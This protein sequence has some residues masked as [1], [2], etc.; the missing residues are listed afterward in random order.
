[1]VNRYG[2]SCVTVYF[3]KC[4][5]LSPAAPWPGHLLLTADGPI[6]HTKEGDIGRIKDYSHDVT[7]A[8]EGRR[9]EQSVCTVS[10]DDISAG[11]YG[12][13]REK[14]VVS[15]DADVGHG[16]RWCHWN[17]HEKMQK[18][19]THPDQRPWRSP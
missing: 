12:P 16:R 5:T 3:C 17:R 18:P 8:G 15:P 1:M 6:Q 4:L 10:C 11:R 14:T 9:C 19:L 13:R 7:A 2:T